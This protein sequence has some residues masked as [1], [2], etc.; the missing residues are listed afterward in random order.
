M[1]P[2]GRR[3]ASDA[4]AAAVYRQTFADGPLPPPPKLTGDC[5]GTPGSREGA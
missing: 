1:T 5:A 3:T 4:G 2:K